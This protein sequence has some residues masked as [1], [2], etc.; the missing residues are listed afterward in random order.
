MNGVSYLATRPA[1]RR[2]SCWTCGGI[3]G[4][5]KTFTTA[6]WLSRVGMSRASRWTRY[7]S[8]SCGAAPSPRL[9]HMPEYRITFARSAGRELNRLDPPIARRVLPAIEKLA[10]DARPAG[11]VKLTGSQNDWRIRVGNWRV[12]Y[13]IGDNALAVDIV[14]IRHRSDAYR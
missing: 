4:S 9:R 13:T 7:A 12:I 6:C 5:G 2:P 8:G 1:T 3:E 11:C 10:E 14:A